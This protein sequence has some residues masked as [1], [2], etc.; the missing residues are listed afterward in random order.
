MRWSNWRKITDNDFAF[1]DNIRCHSGPA[2]YELAVAGPRGGNKKVVYIGETKLEQHR[3][4]E[5]AKRGSHLVNLID[6]ETA[7]GHTIWYR[8]IAR[9]SKE[10]AKDMQDRRLRDY[11][12]PWNIHGQR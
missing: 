6:A 11:T 4:S 5:Y 10:D 9:A 2:V 1:L 7:L 8:A 3:I 12:Y